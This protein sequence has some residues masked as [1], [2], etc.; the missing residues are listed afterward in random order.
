MKKN[1]LVAFIAI[2]TTLLVG[3]TN[4]ENDRAITLD[5]TE[6]IFDAN[7]TR[8]LKVS[9]TSNIEWSVEFMNETDSEWITITPK[10]GSND[11]E[12]SVTV[13]ENMGKEK[14]AVITIGEGAL[15]KVLNISQSASLYNV[16]DFEDVVLDPTTKQSLGTFMPVDKPSLDKKYGYTKFDATLTALHNETYDSWKGVAYSS[17]N[18]KEINGLDNQYSVYHKDTETGNGG[19]Y[20]SEKF[21]I[22]Y[23]MDFYP[24]LPPSL[25]F[26]EGTTKTVDHLFVNNSTYLT[27]TVLNGYGMSS[28]FEDGDWFKIT[29]T[30]YNVAG[31]KGKSVEFYLADY[32]DGKTTIIEDWTK[33]SLAELGEVNKINFTLQ[34]S[35]MNDY[36]MLTPAYV[37]VDNIAITK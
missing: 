21:A 6:L 36:G 24:D 18:N 35:D 2:F 7:D 1:L 23:Y 27:L 4:S 25:S 15:T 3:C 17:N 12:I 37:C 10:N 13:T 16:I 34:T 31:E 8:A 14:D 28:K 9:I 33:I 32:R 20:G 11:G 30:G 22:M 19:V 5:K 29:I 26:P